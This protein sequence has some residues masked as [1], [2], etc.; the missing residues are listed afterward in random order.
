MT[1]LQWN[2]DVLKGH[3]TGKIIMFTTAGSHH[4]ELGSFLYINLLIA[5][6]KTSYCSLHQIIGVCY[7]KIP[8][9]SIVLIL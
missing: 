3:R 4:I 8:Q 5:G 1:F 2:H 6:L 7:F 9:L